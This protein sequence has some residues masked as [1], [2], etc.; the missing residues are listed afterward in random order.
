MRKVL[1]NLLIMATVLLAACSQATPAAPPAASNPTAPS[2]PATAANPTATVAQAVNTPTTST[3]TQSAA[4]S[5][6]QPASAAQ[7]GATGEANAA[8]MNCQVVST[9]PTQGPTEISMF[10]PAGK[11]DWVL[12]KNANA[13]LTIIEYSD[14]Q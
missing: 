1:L 14:F 11:D 8:K 10:P 3:A 5:A 12:G 2:S 9:S 7:P 6:T 13:A 4:Q